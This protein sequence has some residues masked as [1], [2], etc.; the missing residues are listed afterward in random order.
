LA[1]NHKPLDPNWR[2]FWLVAALLGASGVGCG[3]GKSAGSAGK[4]AGASTATAG[5]TSAGASNATG[6]AAAVSGSG[7]GAEAG[8]TA[9]GGDNA[10]VEGSYDV[11]TTLPELPQLE[12]VVGVVGDDSVVISFQPVDDARDYR[13]YVLPADADVAVAGAEVAVHNAIY[14]CSGDREVPPV[15]VDDGP[16]GTNAG[17]R[18]LVEDQKVAGYTRKLDEAELGRV[19]VAAGKA[20]VPVY[21]LG[22]PDAKSDNWAFVGRVRASR[23][24]RY[25]TSAADRDSLLASGWRDDGVAFYVPAEAT[26]D[27]HP[28]YTSLDADGHTRFYVVD[29]AE[30]DMR[31]SPEIA[32]PVLTGEAAGTQPL[33]RVF[34]TKYQAFSHDELAV[35]KTLFERVRY[36]GSTQPM[37]ELLWSGITGPTTLVVEAL[38]SGCPYP[39]RLAAQNIAAL[40]ETGATMSG[41]VDYPEAIT[42]ADAQAKAANGE[43]Y[44]NGQHDPAN[45]PH[46]VARAFLKVTPQKHETFDWFADFAPKSEL[47]GFAE[48][49]C[50]TPS[51]NCFQQWRQVS[52][53]YDVNW[54]TIVTGERALGLEFGELWVRYADW[55]ADTNGKFRLTPSHK[56]SMSADSYLHAT[57]EVN[58]ITTGRRYPQLLISDRDAPIQDFLPQGSTLLLQ[59]FQFWPNDL[60]IQICDHRTWDVNNQCPFFQ[61]YTRKDAKGDVT[62]LAPVPEVGEQTAPDRRTRFD[63]YVSAKRA[64]VFLDLQPYGC[65]DLPEN[66]IPQG[67]VTVTFGDVLYHSDADF[68][69]G[70]HNTYLHYDTERHFDNLGFSSG[71]PAPRWDLTRFP[72]VAASSIDTH[73]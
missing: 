41:F 50:G 51:G 54:H 19:Y 24:K 39:G 25:T 36:Q 46:A 12:H 2:T 37:T 23:T 21:A 20:R 62:S 64:Y 63:L 58:A 67:D 45:T 57:M 32:F 61:F 22:D 38:D 10:T 53:D 68:P 6:G 5:A 17:T 7:S 44:I 66:G 3:G 65:V 31:P 35:G 72:C 47:A 69:L 33:Y 4:G 60:E 55:A 70:Y 15:D 11:P 26:A 40:H 43:L 29:G 34:Y 59:P 30:K 1:R 16:A 27:T 8:S 56:A 49:D 52:D 18:T 48:V 71:V 14:R 9:P 13:V 28:V 73:K 42:P